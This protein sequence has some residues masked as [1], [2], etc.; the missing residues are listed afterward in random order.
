MEQYELDELAEQYRRSKQAEQ[1][2]KRV[3]QKE[4]NN[5]ILP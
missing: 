4:K 5:D 2:E 1:L 3:K